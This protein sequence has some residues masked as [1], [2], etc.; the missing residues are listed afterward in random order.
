MDFR[1][2]GKATKMCS[3]C[4]GKKQ[5]SILAKLIELV[6]NDDSLNDMV[7]VMV[8][9]D[10]RRQGMKN[11]KNNTQRELQQTTLT[12][13][14]L[15]KKFKT[16]LEICIPHCQEIR[17]IRHMMD[18]DFTRLA[19]DTILIFTDFAA[20]MALR[21]F[22]AKNSSV[23]GHAICDNM[24]C[25]SNRRIASVTKKEKND[26]ETELSLEVFDIDVHHFFAET[27]EKGKKMIMQCTTL[28]L[29]P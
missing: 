29:M 25:I 7:D 10:A 1:K 15:V 12:V 18:S 6:E 4:Q 26:S 5:L 2:D 8:W 14:D 20:V 3:F 21:A 22:Q 19:Q 23:D 27:I 11:G 28:A 13:T 24:V 16:Q 9:V 17:W